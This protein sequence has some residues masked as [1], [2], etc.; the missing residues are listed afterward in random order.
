VARARAPW[1]GAIAATW[2]REF[3]T[4]RL[5]T[6][7]V[8]QALSNARAL[9]TYKN[10]SNLWNVWQRWANETGVNALAASEKDVCHYLANLATKGNV[11]LGTARPYLSAIN[12]MYADLGLG[13]GPARGPLVAKVKEGLARMQV[14]TR[15]SERQLA[16]PAHVAKKFHDFA[17][18]L[19]AE[20][21]CDERA[22]R[23]R[24]HL[25]GAL[26]FLTGSRT[27]SMVALPK[28]NV[29]IDL[30][31]E[32]GLVVYRAF[33]KTLQGDTRVGPGRFALQFPTENFRDFVA[34]L[35]KFAAYRDRVLPTAT[36]FFQLPQDHFQSDPEA[37]SPL[38]ERWLRAAFLEV[39]DRPP[40]GA[41]WGPRSLRSGA[42][43]AA[44]AAGVPRSKT[45]FLGGWTPDSEALATHYIDPSIQHS[46]AGEFFF[47]HLAAR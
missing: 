28:E 29:L 44:E 15:P 27:V 19:A 18:D 17:V 9:K 23:W 1:A 16:L 43:S 20:G 37:N 32:R 33:T 8:V 4:R 12:A 26:T 22:G 36:Y 3:G 39:S 25:S 7:L 24:N 6:E 45:E 10:Y 5:T 13:E 34:A 40:A 35:A 14:D 31:A 47:G 41:V 21:A 2:R 46:P 42:A 30:A 38:G 11:A